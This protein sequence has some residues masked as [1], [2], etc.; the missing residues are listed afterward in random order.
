MYRIRP[1][2]TSETLRHLLLGGA[3]QEWLGRE[4]QRLKVILSTIVPKN[5][6][7]GETLQDGGLPA[8]GLIDYLNEAEWKQVQE[9][10]FD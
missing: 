4:V 5:P 3:A 6:V 2:S 1:E 7:L 9:K 8:W 10:I